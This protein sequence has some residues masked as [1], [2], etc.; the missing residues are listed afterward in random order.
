MDELI[1]RLY[2]LFFV[3]GTCFLAL[4]WHLKG[5]ELS[6]ARPELAEG[7]RKLVRGLLLWGNLPWA[8][9]GVGAVTGTVP[10]IDDFTQPRGGNPF[11]V[12]FHASIVLIYVLLLR[13]VLFKD[14]ARMLA[15]HPG[16][17]YVYVGLWGRDITSPTLIRIS[18]VVCVGIGGYME[19]MM[20]LGRSL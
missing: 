17:L 6:R 18:V 2:W 8:V 12:A 5:V 14:G 13:W 10:S 9:M 4:L 15:D 16:L 11:V 19:I 7:Y 1:Q 20:W 3:L